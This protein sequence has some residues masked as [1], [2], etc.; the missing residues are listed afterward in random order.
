MQ[1]SDY[2]VRVNNKNNKNNNKAN[3]RPTL[4]VRTNV[5]KNTYRVVVVVV[6]QPK[7]PKLDILFDTVFFSIPDELGN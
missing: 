4:Y 7:S 1:Y 5:G 2:C 3:L 6:M